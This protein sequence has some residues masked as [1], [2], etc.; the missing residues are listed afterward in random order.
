MTTAPAHRLLSIDAYRALVML[1]MIFVNDTWTLI[2]I[3]DWIGHLPAEADGLGLADVVFPAFL[4]I[5]GLSM[6]FAMQSR[7]KKGDSRWKIAA[8]VGMR[9]LALIVMGFFHVNFGD[10]ADTALLPKWIWQVLVTVGFFLVWLDYPNPKATAAHVLKTVGCAALMV[11]AFVFRREEQPE[12]WFAM[13]P[14]WWGILGLIGW[15]Y[16]LVAVAFLLTKGRAWAQLTVFVGFILFNMGAQSSAFDWLM[17]VRRHAWIVGDGALPALTACGV[18]I[19]LLYQRYRSDTGSFLWRA[20]A[21]AAVLIAFGLLARQAWNISKIW[22]TPSFALVC[23]GISTAG[24]ALMVYTVDAKRWTGWY[25]FV[26]PAGTSTLTCYLLP[27]I[28][29]AVLGY[30]GWQLPEAL[31]TGVIGIAKSI[32]YALLII[33][34]TGVLERQRIRLKL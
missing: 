10:Y 1:L 8:H 2:A 32:G 4:F 21:A 12:A 31:R 33:A 3:P 16:L 23:A 26:K 6:P 17:G 29:Y 24:F 28:H 7:L 30:I 14:Q 15:S 20:T 13:R 22:A 9:S 18:L 34:V 11:L 5:V 19:S 27:Y 25:R